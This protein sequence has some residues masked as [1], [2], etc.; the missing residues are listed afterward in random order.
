MFGG[1]LRAA[2][3]LQQSREG[4]TITMLGGGSRTSKEQSHVPDSIRRTLLGRV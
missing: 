4:D 3:L 1:R 2:E